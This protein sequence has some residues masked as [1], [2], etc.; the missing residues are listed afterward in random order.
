MLFGFPWF[1]KIHIYNKKIIVGNTMNHHQK[2]ATHVQK[3]G[4]NF[5][6]ACGNPCSQHLKPLTRKASAVSQK[7]RSPLSKTSQRVC[8]HAKYNVMTT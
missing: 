8:Q 1:L 2:P 4:Q 7:P 5:N 3:G 6:H